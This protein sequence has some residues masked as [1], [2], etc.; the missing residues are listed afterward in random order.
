MGKRLPLALLDH[1]EPEPNSGC[2]LWLGSVTVDGYGHV[3]RGRRASLVHR[4]VYE[5]TVGPIP[6]GLTIDHLCRV[7]SCLNVRHM[8]P[9]T[10]R[11]NSLRGQGIPA[12]NARKT[13]C[14]RGHEYRWITLRGRPN[15][16]RDCM[17][18]VRARERERYAMK[19]SMNH[20]RS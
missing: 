2:L 17:T 11:V 16:R 19:R 20:G 3:E 15:A 4:L 8:E 13:Q 1:V 12:V 9:V 5:E 14:P 10:S 6:S 7:R 18:C